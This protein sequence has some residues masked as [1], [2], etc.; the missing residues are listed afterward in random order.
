MFRFE[1]LYRFTDKG[2]GLPGTP[3]SARELNPRFEDIDTRLATVETGVSDQV[4][5]TNAALQSG[6]SEISRIM[7]LITGGNVPMNGSDNMSLVWFGASYLWRAL[8]V[9]DI[10]NL[11]TLLDAKLGSVSPTFTGNVDMHGATSATV[12]TAVAGDSSQKAANTQ[13]VMGQLATL[14]G[15]ATP[16]TLDTLQEIADALGDD[17]NFATTILALVAQ[18]TTAA[19]GTVELA[20]DAETATGTD[21]TRPMTPANLKSMIGTTADYLANTSGKLLTTDQVNAAGAYYALTDASTIAIDMRNGTNFSV[22]LGGNRIIGNPTY[23]I[24]GRS[25]RFRFTQPASGGPRT[26]SSWASYWVAEGHV[27]PVL[28]TAANAVDYV[29]YDIDAPTKIIVTGI[30][31]AVS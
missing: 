15:G 1:T 3:L 20:T 18:A 22:T 23:A 8:M 26:I 30:R 2:G 5:A 9:S 24:A 12:P 28:S 21:A 10:T 7:A 31:K 6:L 19:R 25:G 16:S 27:F 13:W 17:P 14:I 11:Q 4:G 29:Y